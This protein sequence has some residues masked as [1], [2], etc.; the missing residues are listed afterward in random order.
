[1]TAVHLLAS[2]V[3]GVAPGAGAF[4]SG[5]AREAWHVIGGGIAEA[6]YML[7]DTLW[8][9]VAGFALSGI[10]QA[11]VSR[12]AMHRALGRL[13]AG[14]VARASLLGAA[15]SSCSYAASALAKSLFARSA[16]FT[17]SMVFMFASTNLNVAIGLVIWLLV[18]WQFALAQFAGGAIMI[19]LLGLLLPRLVPAA[20]RQAARQ[21]LADTADSPA[22]AADA[23]PLR[24]RLRSLGSWADAAGY[25]ISDLTMLRKELLG[26]LLIAGFLTAGVP[27]A[28]WQA[29][30]LTGHGAWSSIENAVLGPLI[31]VISFVCSVGNVPLAAALWHGGISFGGTVAFIFADLITLPLLLIYRKFYGGPMALRMLAGFWLVMS[32]AGLATEYLFRALGLVPATRPVTVVP[33]G[34]HWDYTTILNIFALAAFGALYWAYRSRAR[35]GGGAGYATDVVC[36]MQV[37]KAAAPAT[38]RHQGQVFY[39]CSDRCQE[40]FTASPAK[41]AG[42]TMAGPAGTRPAEATGETAVTDPVCGM[43][44]D[45]G[46]DPASGTYAGRDYFFCATGCRD[47]FTADPL[48][49][50]AVARDPVC[51]M[52]VDAAR[53]AATAEHDGRRYLFCSDG[54]RDSFTAGP[55]QYLTHETVP[56]TRQAG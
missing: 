36:G 6:F 40:R 5:P 44:V 15:S 21:R 45:P 4:A 8:A 9:I 33:P 38:A 1:M 48:A 39:F 46:Q 12:A 14:T 16:D 43:T 50:L 10:V 52:D 41:Y 30:F 34:V 47:Q 51:G 29:L 26:G 42:A 11:F 22:G 53:P 13:S 37:E 31:A 54:C 32:A 18:G 19:V 23:V 27:A 7:W 25:A 3:P 20:M 55:G 17:A 56:G 49:C 24:Q 28:A 35:L 2:Q